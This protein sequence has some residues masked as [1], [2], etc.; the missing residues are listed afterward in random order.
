M[1]SHVDEFVGQRI[2]IARE[3]A[4]MREQDLADQLDVT[5]QQLSLYETG[6]ARVPASR[7]SLLCELLQLPVAWFFDGYSVVNRQERIDAE[8]KA[9]ELSR[10]ELLE[11]FERL[12]IQN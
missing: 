5:V 12:R 9:R 8:H 10:A 4:G 11:M 7:L 3:F 2:Q 6:L 1:K